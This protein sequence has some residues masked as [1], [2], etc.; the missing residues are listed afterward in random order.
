M[1]LLAI[2]LLVSP[3]ALPA[4]RPAAKPALQPAELPADW[5]E[6]DFEGKWAAYRAGAT[7]PSMRERWALVLGRA[8]ENELLEAIT[9]YEGWK[10]FGKQLD[11]NNAPQLLRAAHWNLGAYDSHDKDTANQVLLRRAP[12]TLA[13]LNAHPHAARGKGAAL[14]DKL[15]ATKAAAEAGQKF[16][17]PLDAMQLLVPALDAPAELLDFGDRLRAV[18]GERYVHQVLRALSGVLVYGEA[19]DLVVQ[20]VLRLASH[21]NAA[22]RG[23]AFTTLSKLPPGLVP[24]VGLRKLADDPRLPDEQRQLATLTLSFSAH[25]LAFFGVHEIAH[26]ERH[27]GRIAALR[28]LGEIGDATTA[29]ELQQFALQ[30][31]PAAQA[32]DASLA[33]YETR[34]KNGGLVQVN[35]VLALAWRT[36]WLRSTNDPRA[37]AHHDALRATLLPFVDA[38]T[39]LGTLFERYLASGEAAATPSPFRGDE[40]RAVQQQLTQMLAELGET[41]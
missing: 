8:N 11:Q 37:A 3:S 12:L 26:D 32:L 25:P 41:K 23:Q 29:Q 7:D 39:T 16:L 14:L 10:H 2:V 18:P 15:A 40:Q 22:V 4:Q 20:K 28:R 9:L 21:Q 27:P 6:R 1:R 19:D 36:A 35:P 5:A 34:R 31:G 38:Q 30:A 17:P 33:T 24:H 13:W